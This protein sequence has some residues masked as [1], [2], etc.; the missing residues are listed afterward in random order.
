M[1]VSIKAGESANGQGVPSASSGQALRFRKAIRFASRLAP[2]RMT[3]VIA[4]LLWSGVASATT[5]YVSSS[6]GN[7]ANNGTSTSTAWQTI[8]QVNG[9]SFQPGDSILFK[10]G[11]VWNESLVPASSGSSGNPITF[12]AYGTGAAPNLTGYY[13]VPASAWVLVTG[14]AWKAAGA[15]DIH[16]DQFLSVWIGVG[17]EG[18]GVDVE[19][20]GAVGFLSG[21]WVCCMCTR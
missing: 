1:K 2:F 5:Y 14:N 17:A 10:R 3:S 6:M 7:D 13:A 4:L 18:C 9:R 21:E 12:D 16:D 20:D 19:L 15:G 11:D 8:A